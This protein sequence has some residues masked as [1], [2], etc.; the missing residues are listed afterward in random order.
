MVTRKRL[1]FLAALIAFGMAAGAMFLAWN[2]LATAQ[3]ASP[4]E[5]SQPIRSGTI[6]PELTDNGSVPGSARVS[7]IGHLQCLDAATGHPIAGASACVAPPVSDGVMPQPVGPARKSD[8]SGRLPLETAWTGTELIIDCSGYE[9]LSLKIEDPRSDAIA[10]LSPSKISTVCCTLDGK[11]LSECIVF[12]SPGPIQTGVGYTIPEEKE[13]DIVTGDPR[14]PAMDRVWSR[15]TDQ[16]GCCTFDT[17]PQGNYY[18]AVFHVS[19]F[20]EDERFAGTAHVSPALAIGGL[21]GVAMKRFYGSAVALDR[22]STVRGVIA[23]VDHATTANLPGGLARFRY[24]ERALK[25][26]LGTDLVRVIIPAPGIPP[27]SL[28]TDWSIMDTEGRLWRQKLPMQPLD[29]LNAPTYLEMIDRPTGTMAIEIRTRSNEPFLGSLVIESTE[30]II[31]S[32]TVRDG[33]TIKLPAGNFTWVLSHP[34]PWIEPPQP[35]PLFQ[36]KADTVTTCQI[37]IDDCQRVIIVP[38]FAANPMDVAALIRVA[39]PL[40]SANWVWRTESGPIEAFLPRADLEITATAPGFTIVERTVQATDLHDGMPI[41]IV[42]VP[43]PK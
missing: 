38:R 16:S 28:V 34:N 17:L 32:T 20:P 43:V 41:E 2:Q 26:R 15:R 40:G 22:E 5:P 42:M 1:G 13:T 27:V 30:E 29:E 14:S 31:P 3:P 24:V 12:V 19:Y 11:P 35:A 7:A 37:T 33:Q 39:T 6:A 36:V 23:L 8:A 4:S 21:T 25:K 10:R 9:S 18:V